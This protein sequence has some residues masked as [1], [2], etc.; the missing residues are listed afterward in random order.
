MVYRRGQDLQF[1]GNFGHGQQPE[2]GE[3][4]SLVMRFKESHPNMQWATMHHIVP[5]NG[6]GI[7]EAIQKGTEIAV[8]KG[9][10]SGTDGYFSFCFGR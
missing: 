6:E 10:F 1:S 8:T 4:E 9:F 5:D 2:L 7:A 3:P